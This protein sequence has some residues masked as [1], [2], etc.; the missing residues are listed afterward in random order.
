MIVLMDHR[1]KMLKS[2]TRTMRLARS[3]VLLTLVILVGS[4]AGSDEF[5]LFMVCM[6]TTA[7]SILAYSSGRCAGYRE[8]LHDERR[9]TRS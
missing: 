3:L 4:L 9:V 2:L 8:G 1:D 6:S 5:Q 7:L